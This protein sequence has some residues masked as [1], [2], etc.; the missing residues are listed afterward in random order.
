[1]SQTDVANTND[2][3]YKRVYKKYEQKHNLPIQIGILLIILLYV[4]FFMS[5]AI[6]QNPSPTEYTAINKMQPLGNNR[7][8]AVEMWKYSKSQNLMEVQLNI[9][10]KAFDGEDYYDYTSFV[11]FLAESKGKQQLSVEIKLQQVNFVVIWLHDV[12]EDFNSCSLNII[13][14]NDDKTHSS[15]YTNVKKVSKVDKI[16]EKTEKA[17]QIEKIERGISKYKKQI[18][19]N[20]KSIEKLREEI[21]N[22]N[23]HIEK[24]KKDEVYQSESEIKKSEEIIEEYNNQIDDRERQI[25][26]LT[27]DNL[28]Y[29][30]KIIEYEE[31]KNKVSDKS[32]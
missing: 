11:N 13:L 16:S 28:D 10:N 21:S 12:P 17:Y 7:N 15:V 14:K 8:V 24:V 20:N 25:T 5:S 32:E 18:V 6:F 23:V 1:M 30:S 27:N 26:S 9:E 22:I 31:L 19:K 4:F 3:D 2:V 29:K